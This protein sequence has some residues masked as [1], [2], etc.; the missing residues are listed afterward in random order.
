[1]K[2][3]GDNRNNV[4]QTDGMNSMD[5]ASKQRGYLKEI[6]KKNEH[7]YSES[8]ESYWKHNE[9]VVISHIEGRK[10]RGT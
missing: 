6:G 10:Y 9:E 1:M 2:K 4:L 3:T 8:A 7:L 5:R